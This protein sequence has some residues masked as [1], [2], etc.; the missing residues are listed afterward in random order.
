MIADPL[1][2]D[3]VEQFS[4]AGFV[5]DCLSALPFLTLLILLVGS[6]NLF[7][8][9]EQN[10]AKLEQVWVSFVLNKDSMCK[11]FGFFVSF[12][13]MCADLSW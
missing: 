7:I 8:I 11:I 3:Q 9:V 10:L 4:A 1:C 12:G 6:R 2:I 5:V 13:S